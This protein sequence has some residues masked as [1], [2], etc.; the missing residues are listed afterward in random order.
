MPKSVNRFGGAQFSVSMWLYIKGA[1]SDAHVSRK[2]LFMRGDKVKYAPM[3]SPDGETSKHAYFPGKEKNMDYA[4]V[5]PK[6]HFPTGQNCSNKLLI[7]LNTDKQLIQRFQIGSDEVDLDLRKNLVSAAP[8]SWTMITIYA[9]DMNAYDL[10]NL[11]KGIRVRAF[12]QDTLY[13]EQT[14]PGSP[15]MNKGPTHILPG[16]NTETGGI[17]NAFMPDIV[18]H[19]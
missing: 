17:T 9:Y 13:T 6:I 7:D 8:N 2:T 11:E 14:A 12:I 5:C 10:S 4:I 16:T 15:R 18:W 3:F 1:V 19:N